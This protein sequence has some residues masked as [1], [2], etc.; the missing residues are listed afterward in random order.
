MQRNNA[1]YRKY[2]NIK[3]YLPDYKSTL[4]YKMTSNLEGVQSIK[5]EFVK[6]KITLS[7]L[8]VLLLG[9][10]FLS[11][12]HIQMCIRDRL[13]GFLLHFLMNNPFI[14][15]SSQ[16]LPSMDSSWIQTTRLPDRPSCCQRYDSH[17]MEVWTVRKLSELQYSSLH[18]RGSLMRISHHS[19]HFFQIYV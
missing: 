3:R 18:C 19:H 17:L 12:I 16:Q 4:E 11:L 9:V 15:I 13:L 5:S 1:G 7:A 2:L 10:L 6:K 14:R 8:Y